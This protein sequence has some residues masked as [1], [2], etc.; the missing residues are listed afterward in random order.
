M[1]F[2]LFLLRVIPK[3]S[4]RF[5]MFVLV[6]FVLVRFVLVRFVRTLEN[7]AAANHTISLR[8]QNRAIV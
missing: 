2:L 7:A 8:I 1:G 6:R 4:Q 5:P 3:Q